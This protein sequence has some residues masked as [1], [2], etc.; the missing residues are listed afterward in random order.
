MFNICIPASISEDYLIIN[1]RINNEQKRL[2][3]LFIAEI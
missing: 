1:I 2:A 3:V